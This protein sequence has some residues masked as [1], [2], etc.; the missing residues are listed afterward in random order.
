M[1]DSIAFFLMV[2][3]VVLFIRSILPYDR[4]MSDREIRK[5]CQKRNLK[6]K[7]R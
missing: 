3:M 1:I 7:M 4:E 6:C 5:N 2:V